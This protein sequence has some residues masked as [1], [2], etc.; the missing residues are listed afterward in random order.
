MTC[1][2]FC[3]AGPCRSLL[4]LRSTPFKA[5]LQ[6]ANLT[7]SRYYYEAL[8]ITSFLRFTFY[9]L[10]AGSTDESWYD[11]AAVLESDCSE[12]DFQSVLDGTLFLFIFGY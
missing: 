8:C 9:Y 12:E 10:L 4:T 1:S 5:L 3:I 11:S 2:C 7:L 6:N